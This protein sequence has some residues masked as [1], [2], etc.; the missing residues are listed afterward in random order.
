M[1]TDNS[2]LYVEDLTN[3]EPPFKVATPLRISGLNF[4]S[5]NEGRL[6]TNA[7]TWSF[8]DDGSTGLEG[9]GLS[10]DGS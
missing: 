8:Q 2:W 7:G 9:Y 6:L 10:N 5:A 1:A 4:D 3:E